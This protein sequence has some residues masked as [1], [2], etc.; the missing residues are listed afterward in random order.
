MFYFANAKHTF[1]KT[2]TLTVLAT[3]PTTAI[4]T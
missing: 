3:F 1:T 4:L 2:L